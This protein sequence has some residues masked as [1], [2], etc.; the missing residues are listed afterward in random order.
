MP[1]K[2]KNIDSSI[3]PPQGLNTKVFAK[4]GFLVPVSQDIPIYL[5][6]P[7]TMD[8]IQPPSTKHI[9]PKCLRKLNRDIEKHIDLKHEDR[10]YFMNRP[11]LSEVYSPIRLIEECQQYAYPAIG[12][13]LRKG[14]KSLSDAIGKLVDSPAIFICP[15]R[16]VD[17]CKRISS[18]PGPEL[19]SDIFLAVI[20]HELSHAYRDSGDRHKTLAEHIVEESLVE[21]MSISRFIDKKEV[22]HV[23]QF[24]MNPRRPAEYLGAVYWIEISRNIPLM[25]V[26][27]RWREGLVPVPSHT[28]P[29]GVPYPMN[30]FFEWIGKTGNERLVENLANEILLHV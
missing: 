6:N 16:I 24:I 22:E 27:D 9:D 11:T 4:G 3:A 14:G 2:L 25:V 29:Y 26:A 8:I 7:T 13:Y 18:R 21:A 19:T 5:V 17:A 10:M 15:E 23:T 1:L 30:S 12:V 28:H 20:F